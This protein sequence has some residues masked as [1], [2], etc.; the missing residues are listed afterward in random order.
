MIRWERALA[1]W[2]SCVVASIRTNVCGM[3]PDRSDQGLHFTL[4]VRP[5]GSD[6]LGSRLLVNS[7]RVGEG[8]GRQ[9][10]DEGGDLHLSSAE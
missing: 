7:R 9:G 5:T 2:A 4:W 6:S 10:E 1:S 3:D 8:G